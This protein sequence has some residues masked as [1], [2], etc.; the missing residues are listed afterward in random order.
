MANPS[1]TVQISDGSFTNN[2][3][4]N[5]LRYKR[6]FVRVSEV[7]HLKLEFIFM[8]V[9]KRELSSFFLSSKKSQLQ[10][11]AFRFDKKEGSIQVSSLIVLSLV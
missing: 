4:Q 10:T 9:T 6:N 5:I 3:E 7:E 11:C 2:W 8:S 1:R